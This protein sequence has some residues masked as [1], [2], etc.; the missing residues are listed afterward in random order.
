MTETKAN[1]LT[2]FQERQ[3]FILK[4]HLFDEKKLRPRDIDGTTLTLPYPKEPEPS[5]EPFPYNLI[6]ARK[7]PQMTGFA[8]AVAVLEA[9]GIIAFHD[10]V[11]RDFKAYEMIEA[12]V[13][14]RQEKLEQ[15]TADQNNL[16]DFK[17]TQD[18]TL[19]ALA[20]ALDNKKAV[21]LLSESLLADTAFKTSG[22][23]HNLLHIA[24]ICRA[25][26][27]IPLLLKNGVDFKA[28][29]VFG[30]TPYDYVL[31][32]EDQKQC[33][34]L[35]RLKEAF[36]ADRNF[37]K[38]MDRRGKQPV[39]VQP[40]A[41]TPQPEPKPE[42][43]VVLEELHPIHMKPLAEDTMPASSLEDALREG[44]ASAFNAAASDITGSRRVLPP[45]HFTK[46]PG[47]N[48]KSGTVI[49]VKP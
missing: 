18:M 41:V 30:R 38:Y 6:E 31:E 19:L 24:V 3:D 29:D 15:L 37:K 21:E 49:E 26:D 46:A 9:C 16:S 11:P 4:N 34:Q 1:I 43:E 10:S 40:A 45:P 27:S 12:V 17:I 32:L 47:R 14:H 39:D 7:T 5:S 20:V 42:T 33:E 13:Y 48:S 36:S 23:R 44:L 25:Y 35:A 2:P 8:E 22:H 28:K